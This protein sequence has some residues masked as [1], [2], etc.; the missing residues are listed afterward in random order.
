MAGWIVLG[1]SLLLLV[2]LIF[3]VAVSVQFV[4]ELKIRATYLWVPVFRYPGKPKKEKIKK[5]KR[6]K[7]A[8]PKEKKKRQILPDM[9][10]MLKADGVGAT[11]KYLAELAK[12]A[13][14]AAKYALAA[15]TVV[16]CDLSLTVAGEEAADTALTYG[17]LCGP[18]Y[19]AWAVLE[20]I[21]K[22]KRRR[23]VFRP[24]FRLEASAVR[25]DVKLRV[26]PIK[27][28]WG[29]IKI[30]VSMIQKQVKQNTEEKRGTVHG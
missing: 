21:F 4:E 5:Q 23:I 25:A 9:G 11:V 15:V 12:L 19:A 29:G 17:R 28:L 30:L 7:K 6:A 22:I 20:R 3:P 16:K 26:S 24:D 2:L 27:L 18:F 8:A 14:T 10:K 1:V 13:L